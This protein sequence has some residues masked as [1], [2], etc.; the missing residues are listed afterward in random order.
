MKSPIESNDNYEIDLIEILKLII[1]NKFKFLIVVFLTFLF[2]FIYYSTKKRFLNAEVILYPNNLVSS[3]INDVISNPKIITGEDLVRSYANNLKLKKITASKDNKIILSNDLSSD[4]LHEQS[5]L[6]SFLDNLE[7]KEKYRKI[8]FEE[9]LVSL[10]KILMYDEN[11]FQPT[12]NISI[13]TPEALANITIQTKIYD[14]KKYNTELERFNLYNQIIKNIHFQNSELIKD[15]ISR[16]YG[17][18]EDSLKNINI[19]NF[20]PYLTKYS[21]EYRIFAYVLFPIATSTG[22]ALLLIIKNAISKKTKE[23]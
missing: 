9:S 19:I 23:N 16:F 3:K 11:K 2:T 13:T 4:Y 14:Q 20:N 8:S 10:R 22:L 6:N 5:I 18:E 7:I 12:A 15:E 17:I 1:K 21:P